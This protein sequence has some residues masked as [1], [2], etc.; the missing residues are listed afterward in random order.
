M[1]D[2]AGAPATGCVSQGTGVNPPRPRPACAAVPPGQLHVLHPGDVAC[3]AQGDRFETLLG[4]CVSIVLT[5]PRRTVAAMCHVVHAG[6]GPRV[7]S[8]NT[9]YGGAA[10]DAM[11]SML[12]A[13]GIDPHQC[14]AYVHGGGNMFPDQFPTLHVGQHNA[15]WALDELE[16]CGVRVLCRDV[17]GSS[18]RRLCW[19]IGTGAPQV[20]AVPV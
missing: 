19:T 10:L 16:R 14:E 9:A 3:A 4:S 6:Q 5:D 1:R 20:T 17:G 15:C 2:I 11:F 7:A 12:R 13:R 8:K 18:Y